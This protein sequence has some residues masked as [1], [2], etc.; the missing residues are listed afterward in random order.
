MGIFSRKPKEE[1]VAVFDIGSGGIGGAL[2]LIPLKKNIDGNQ[3][4]RILFTT[5]TPIIFHNDF[6]FNHFVKLMLE[7]FEITASNIEKAKL[8]APQRAHLFLASPWYVSQTRIIKMK[9]NE[10]FVFNNRLAEELINQEIKSFEKLQLTKFLNTENKPKIIEKKNI[11]TTLNGYQMEKPFAKKAKELEITL[12][13]SMSTENIINSLKNKTRKFFNIPINFSSFLLSSFIVT[14]DLFIDKNNFLLIDISGEITDVSVIK[15]D[16]L[17]ESISFPLGRNFVIRG[18][19]SGFNKNREE[20]TSLLR[21]YNGA[22]LTEEITKKIDKILENSRK[23]WLKEFQTSVVD[24]SDNLIMPDTIF[25]TADDDII[26]WFKEN[27]EKEEFSQ[28]TLTEKKFNIILLD[29]L[30]LSD[31]CSISEETSCDP[32]LIMESISTARLVH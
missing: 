28:Y 13:I 27:I 17:L 22:K 3:K 26:H 10:P 5:R 9:K 16:I 11:K 8:G 18:I 15:N 2:V 31:Y 29:N 25:L 20:S 6:K 12:F 4:S 14:R 30:P 7:A 21:M 1:L 32:F 23:K 24:I 19:M